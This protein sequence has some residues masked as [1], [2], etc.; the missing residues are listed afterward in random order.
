MRR[1]KIKAR[2]QNVAQHLLPMAP[3]AFTPRGLEDVM[4]VQNPHGPD[5]AR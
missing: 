3:S 2:L 5:A 4:S 1:C